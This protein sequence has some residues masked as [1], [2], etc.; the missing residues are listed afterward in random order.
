M[1]KSIAAGRTRAWVEVELDALARNARRFAE[2]MGVPLLPMVKA[3]AY[4]LGAEAVVTVLEPLGP[5]GYGIAT[6]EEGAAL[7]R[8][9]IERPLLLMTPL[10]PQIL[11]GCMTWGIRPAIGNSAMLEAWLA[12]GGGPFHLAVD[13]G[14][15]RAGVAWHDAA[16][17]E[18]LVPTLDATPGFEGMFTHFHS[19]DTDPESC[20]VQLARFHEV[21]ARLA[22]RPPLL[23]AANSAALP[24][25]ALDL[26]R[27]G[28]YL[29]G[30]TAGQAV[31]EPVVRVEARVVA[32]RRVRIGDTVSYGATWRATQ[33]TTIVT[34]ALGYADG[35]P[36]AL[37]GRGGFELQGQRCP[38]AGRVNMDV[39]MVD[40]GALEVKP[41]DIATFLGGTL[42]L[43][44]QAEAANTT[45]YQLL[46][47]LGPRL[48][49][50][51]RRT[52]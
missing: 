5:W 35:V 4:G 36:L 51:Y 45:A 23:H 14:M 17:W 38:V 1:T 40:A 30:G 24:E 43:E 33:P 25:C 12:A 27:P 48:P 46:T 39:T 2:A 49:R 37:A 20:R 16:A 13:T 10:Y 26:A 42:T 18:S 52:A 3:D 41:G 7:R 9:G 28:I 50:H 29:Y 31:P 11:H 47:A 22:R 44:Q 8:Q 15:S 19:A 32:V 21:V 34:V 6:V